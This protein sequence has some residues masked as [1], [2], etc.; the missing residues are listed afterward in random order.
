MGKVSYIIDK[1][2]RMRLSGDLKY[3]ADELAKNGLDM[4]KIREDGYLFTSSQIDRYSVSIN[5][6]LT[7]K[8]RDKMFEVLGLKP[9]PFIKKATTTKQ[10]TTGQTSAGSQTTSSTDINVTYNQ[11]EDI[12]S[13]LR[14]SINQLKSSWDNGTKNNINILNNSWVGQDCVEYTTKLGNMDGRVQNT[15]SALELLCQAYEKARDMLK[16]N[17]NNVLSSINNLD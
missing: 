4:I 8:L 13:T 11:L 5:D 9:D 3:A 7:E 2:G 12:I 16:D 15:I 10:S 14:T 6:R 1:N 17:Q